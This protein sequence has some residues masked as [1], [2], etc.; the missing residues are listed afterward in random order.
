MEERLFDIGPGIF[1]PTCDYEPFCGAADTEFACAPRW[2][3]RDYGG[4]HVIHPSHPD[5]DRH[6]ASVRGPDFMTVRARRVDVPMLPA[7][8]PQIRMRRGLRGSLTERIYGIRGWEVIGKRQKLLRADQIRAE[9]GL[10]PTQKLVLIL[11][12][13]DVL[14]ERLWQEAEV[15]L[16]DLVDAR[17]DLVVGPSYSIYEPR[18]RLEH[19]FNFKRALEVFAR[20]QQLLIPAIPRGGWYTEFDVR[21]LADWLNANRVVRWLGIDLQTLREPT[22][23]SAVLHGFQSLDALTGRRLRYLVN[24][25]TTVARITE[26]Y[27][28]AAIDRVA[29]T[30]ST[31]ASPPPVEDQLALPVDASEGA[32]YAFARR[33]EARRDVVATARAAARHATSRPVAPAAA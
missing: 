11:F 21:R 20:C 29:L 27:N 5:R 8:L 17:F 4:L 3:D 10:Q 19:L 9:L 2:G 32:R 31:L 13:D 6:M 1:C 14:L 30:S 18:P 28:A 22:E 33:C 25:P 24:G 23:W 7:Y 26:V 16:G 12:D 15:L